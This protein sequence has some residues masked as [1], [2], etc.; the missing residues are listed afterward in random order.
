MKS[1]LMRTFL[2]WVLIT[3]VLMS[4]GFF[5]WFWLN[6][7][8][9]GATLSRLNAEQF[10]AQNNRTGFGRLV[11]ECQMYA[12]TNADLARLIAPPAPATPA[13][14]APAPAPAATKKPGAK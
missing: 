12:K 2:E 3:S 5:V 11:A 1:S 10:A 13:S 7:R 4:V 6:S 8:A 14:P 9:I